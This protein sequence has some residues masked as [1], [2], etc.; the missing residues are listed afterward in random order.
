M[1]YL[2]QNES[3]DTK[4]IKR[5]LEKIYLGDFE[6]KE[7]QSE[8]STPGFLFSKGLT[9]KSNDTLILL[10]EH[11]ICL[12][13][14]EM[15]YKDRSE[16]YYVSV[17]KLSG[18]KPNQLIAGD[19]AKNLAVLIERA[20]EV[21]R[22]FQSEWPKRVQID[23]PETPKDPAFEGFLVVSLSHA[24][25]MAGLTAVPSS[26]D[27][28]FF[29]ARSNENLKCDVYSVQGGK[30]HG[31]FATLSSYTRIEK[32]EQTNN[33]TMSVECFAEVR[34]NPAAGSSRRVEIDLEECPKFNIFDR[35]QK[36]AEAS[37]KF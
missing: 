27:L 32:D 10:D 8:R 16:L 17:E 24:N 22:N 28:P 20:I 31:A 26:P 1:K 4:L 15:A 6:L 19:E 5:L 25:R 23:L 7:K 14:P 2:R 3:E 35:L 37:L 13:T 36:K 9:C 34:I 30:I 18:P 11:C 29:L 21:G 33:V 12:S